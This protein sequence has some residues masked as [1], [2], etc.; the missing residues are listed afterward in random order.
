MYYI[1]KGEFIFRQFL[2][3]F[4]AISPKGVLIN[5]FVVFVLSDWIREQHTTTPP[6]LCWDFQSSSNLNEHLKVLSVMVFI[7]LKS[8]QTVLVIKSIFSKSNK[9]FFWTRKCKEYWSITI[10][11]VTWEINNKFHHISLMMVA[12]PFKN[13]ETAE[14]CDL[15]VLTFGYWNQF[16]LYHGK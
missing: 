14:K 11:A 2:V 3:F 6:K 16:S 9:C 4:S 5:S 8:L 13:K 7:T 1:G 15:T 10:S 12:W